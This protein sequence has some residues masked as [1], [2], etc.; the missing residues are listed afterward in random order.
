MPKTIVEINCSTVG[1][2]GRIMFM[3]A[4]EARKAGFKVYTCSAVHGNEKKIEEQNHIYI[5]NKLDKR[6]HLLMAKK[7]GYNG[8]FS[9][10]TTGLFLKKL[11]D[12][13]PDRKST[14]LNSS[15][16]SQSRMPS[17]A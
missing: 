6:L 7:T 3:I 4:K 11:D 16:R 15:H 2:T 13:K 17:S 10:L 1:S 9:H 12:I 8:C 14:R 5:G